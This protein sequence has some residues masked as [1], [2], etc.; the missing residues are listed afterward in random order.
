MMEIKKT[1]IGENVLLTLE[2]RLDTLT[3]PK[4]QEVLIAA[5]PAAAAVD[6]DFAGVEYVSSAGLRVLLLGEKNAKAAGKTMTLKNVS[7]EVMEV[8]EITG[9]AGI[10]TIL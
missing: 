7:A 9:F 2:G 10:L 8:F 1:Q 5:F 3:A 6:L 4:L